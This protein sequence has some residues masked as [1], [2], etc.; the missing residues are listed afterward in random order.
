M[1]SAFASAEWFISLTL[2]RYYEEKHSSTSGELAWD[3]R[4]FQVEF[5]FLNF[6]WNSLSRATVELWK[7]FEPINYNR[8]SPTIGE[9]KKQHTHTEKKK[10]EKPPLKNMH[11]IKALF[12]LLL[13][14]NNTE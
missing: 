9:K 4:L 8:F 2:A 5:S 13:H 1:A 3:M 6:S 7:D 12:L 10:K 11:F 14:H